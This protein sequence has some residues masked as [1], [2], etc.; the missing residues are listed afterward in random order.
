M[1][2]ST[3]KIFKD[4]EEIKD[5]IE[6]TKR[7]Y[8]GLYK[9][10]FSYGLI[11][12]M[13]QI[14]KFASI[15]IWRTG[16]ICGYVN[17]GLE[18]ICDLFVLLYFVKIYRTEQR[19]TNTYYLSTFSIWGVITVS[20]SFLMFGV[21]LFV[22]LSK[23]DTGLQLLALL[24]KYEMLINMLLICTATITVGFIIDQ[25]WMIVLSIFILFV[26][27]IT[28]VFSIDGST[29]MKV[30]IATA[31]YLLITI[32]GYIALGMNLLLKEKKSADI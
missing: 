8:T 26:F 16:G 9:M 5:V 24:S 22:I 18:L 13:K 7:K 23:I 3:A 21:R 2:L 19:T 14:L 4:I 20:T 17:M 25:R 1:E 6:C 31:Y 15:S 27:M 29:Q 11:Q 10:F 12:G 32:F 28:D 30:N